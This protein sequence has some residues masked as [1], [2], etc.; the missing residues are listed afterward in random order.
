MAVMVRLGG[1]RNRLYLE[2]E[3]ITRI[4]PHLDAWKIWFLDRFYVGLSGVA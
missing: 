2:R 1:E 3:R 4:E